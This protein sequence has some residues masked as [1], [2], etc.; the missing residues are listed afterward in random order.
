MN[1]YTLIMAGGGGTRFWP[2][3]RHN[4]PKQLLNLS[5]NDAMINET[6]LRCKDIIPTER[7]F[8]VTN[9]NQAELMENILVEDF[10]RENILKEPLAKNTAPCILYAAM[11]IFEKHGDGVLCVFPSDHYITDVERFHSILNKAIRLAEAENIPVT[12]GIKPTFPSTAYGYIK[13]KTDIFEEHA[14]KLDR[15]VEKPL[16]EKAKEYFNSNEY[17]WNGGIFVWKVSL[18]IELFKRFLPRIYNQFKQMESKFTG[19]DADCLLAE[20]YPNLE[21]IS[22]DYGIMER[23][24]EALVIT[25]DFGWNDVGSW[26]ALGAVFHADD[27][28][29][30]V[31]ADFL[32][33]DTKDCIVYGEKKLIAAVGIHDT[34]IVDTDDALLICSK[35]K[36][37]DVKYIVDELKRRGKTELL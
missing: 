2:L 26:D 6:I 13:R 8:I 7:Q 17:Y 3:S 27:N 34:V 10:P 14:Y 30:I 28:A 21:N 23:L 31:K 19:S 29:N 18:V 37:Q 15:F 20:I 1:K 24:D 32:C 35:H 5:G 16:F 25:S 4:M 9:K 12:L 36:A 11:H 22:V 33:V